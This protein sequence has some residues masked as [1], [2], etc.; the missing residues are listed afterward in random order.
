[1]SYLSRYTLL[2]QSPLLTQAERDAWQPDEEV[3]EAVEP[4]ENK[5]APPPQC[6][7]CKK[8]M[9]FVGTWRPG[10]S[11]LGIARAPP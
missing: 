4:A 5:P 2:K 3:F 7:R 11:T 9:L 6:P 10:Q 1:V 8:P